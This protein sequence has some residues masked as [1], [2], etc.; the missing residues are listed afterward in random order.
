[1]IIIP[2]GKP[3]IW[4]KSPDIGSISANQAYIGTFHKLC[5]AYAKEFDS[6][7][8]IL[9]PYYGFLKPDDFISET[10]DVRFTLK[11]VN[12]NTIQ[13]AELKKQWQQLNRPET[14]LTIL[15]GK[16]FQAL[17]R[18]IVGPTLLL[19]F[20]LAEAGGIGIMQ[21]FLKDAVASKTELPIIKK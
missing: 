5:Q 10:Y 18:E 21:K 9:S 20:P 6:D 11:G 8:L 15:G 19:N 3:K 7:Y 17:L 16:K 1:M 13:L 4:D 2:S 14:T 12:Q